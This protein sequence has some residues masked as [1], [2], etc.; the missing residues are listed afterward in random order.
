MSRSLTRRLRSRRAL[1]GTAVALALGL[2]ATACG[3][4]DD[5]GG[6][7]GAGGAGEDAYGE[8]DL[9]Q[10]VIYGIQ[11]CGVADWQALMEVTGGTPNPEYPPKDV[12]PGAG[13]DPQGV[14]CAVQFV[15]PGL[16]GQS[17]DL[18]TTNF[19]HVAV[20]PYSSSDGAATSYDE[21]LAGDLEMEG[22]TQGDLPGSWDRGYLV[23]AA[24]GSG[25]SRLVSGLVQQGSYLV[26]VR[27]EIMDD[28]LYTQKW[29]F[30]TED[31]VATVTAMVEDLH[32]QVGAQI[33]ASS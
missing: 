7:G 8:A 25:S 27:L 30:T 22:T 9:A 15:L 11:L 17:D 18:F 12:G 33:D 2:M 31:A 32:G 5:G 14:Q 10:D 29:G 16:D 4:D 6:S 1:A 13:I 19:L 28:S 20:V 24:D 23:T 3:G 21:R 26:K